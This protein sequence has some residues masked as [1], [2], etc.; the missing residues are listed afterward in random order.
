MNVLELAQCA[1]DQVGTT[2]PSS[3]ITTGQPEKQWK[4]LL[5]AEAQF[6]RNQCVFPQQKRTFTVTSVASQAEYAFPDD[7]YAA[8]PGTEYDSETEL[9]FIG[10]LSD[11][12]FNELLYG[13]SETGRREYRVFGQD[14]N[15]SPAAVQSKL[16]FVTAPSS[17]GEE[18]TINYVSKNLFLPTSWNS[19][20]TTPVE[21]ISANTDLCV[22]DDDIVLEGIKWRWLK[23]K[24]MDY[25]AEFALHQK[26]IGPAQARWKRTYRG[27]MTGQR[28]R[29][30]YTV[31]EGN[32][33]F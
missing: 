17:N 15:S 32:W 7:F 4:N 24:G 22:F 31:P 3:L 29:S 33:S 16:V 13:V 28:R 27:S 23:A 11:A 26:L 1:A 21:T 6:L 14:L 25:S 5:I 19:S 10:P 20:S 12:R 18:Y 2:A 9:P 30:S 8:L